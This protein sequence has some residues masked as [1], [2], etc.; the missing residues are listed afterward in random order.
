MKINK[1]NIYPSKYIGINAD[2]LCESLDCFSS[3]SNGLFTQHL[4]Y[5][6]HVEVKTL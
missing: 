4:E 3:K 1:K 2:N 5:L 6:L